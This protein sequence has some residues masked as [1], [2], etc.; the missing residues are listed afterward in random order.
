MLVKETPKQRRRAIIYCR[1]S[2]DKQG[3]DGESLEYQ[4]EKGR[5][6]AE[7]HDLDVIM[8]VGTI[9]SVEVAY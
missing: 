9:L 1:V 6:Y 8:R 5:R 3:Q 7:S 2:T 4:E